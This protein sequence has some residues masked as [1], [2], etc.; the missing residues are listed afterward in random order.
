M[1]ID[2]FGLVA[3]FRLVIRSLRRRVV[4]VYNSSEKRGPGL[5]RVCFF[6]LYISLA[7]PPL[8]SSCCLAA[9]L[10][11]AHHHH[12]CLFII[13]VQFSILELLAKRPYF[14]PAANDPRRQPPISQFHD[15]INPI[16]GFCWSYCLLLLL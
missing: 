16:F 15:S 8:H 5:F 9:L 11:R 10:P 2:V 12:P 13:H 7:S 6:L 3:S 1:M 4:G 14:I